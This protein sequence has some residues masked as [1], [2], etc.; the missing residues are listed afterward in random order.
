MA[1]RICFLS[2]MHDPRDKRV[3]QKEAR[4]L[5]AA[6]FEVVHVAPAVD[7]RSYVDSGVSIETYRRP[8]GILSRVRASC[9]LLVRAWS[10]RAD[11]YHCNELDSWLIG[12]VLGFLK[13]R[14]VIFDVH[15]HYP[16]RFAGRGLPEWMERLGSDGVRCMYAILSLR[17]TRIVLAKDSVARDFKVGR[18]KMVVVRNYASLGASVAA[19][20]SVTEGGSHAQS[21]LAIHLGEMSRARGWPQL[22]EA[23][24]HCQAADLKVLL[25]G[26]FTDGSREECLRRATELGVRQRLAVEDWVPMEEAIALV[27]RCSIGLVLFQPGFLNHVFALPHK[28]FEY[29]LEGLPVVAPDFAEEVSDI[30]RSAGCG[31]LVD[32]SDPVAIAVALDVLSE[33]ASLRAVLGENGRRAVLDRYNWEEEGRTL[34]SMYEGLVAG[35]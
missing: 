28:L 31:L 32:V 29:M 13:R 1:T 22:L 21:L 16:S 8:T 20:R 17:T 34:V 10:V 6:G 4:T 14:R 12:S 23:L 7:R 18:N 2:S 11:F 19:G 26:K 35:S 33:D 5:A 25:L 30:V 9:A 27:R 15:E 24:A 3:F